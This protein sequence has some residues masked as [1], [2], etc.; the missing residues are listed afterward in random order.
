[1]SQAQIVREYD[2]LQP[3]RVKLA[4]VAGGFPVKP[5][6]DWFD[7]PHLETETPLTVTADGRVYGHIAPWSA[8][9]IGLPGNVPPPRS[10]SN[11]A[12]F[13]T[14]VVACA[15]GRDVPVGQL[16]MDGGHAPLALDASGAVAH[17]DNTTTAVADVH[18]GED[19]FGIWVA[20][21]LRPN[22]NDLQ[23][24]ALRASA[25]SGDWRPINGGLE[26]VACLQVNTPGFPTVRARVASGAVTAL[27][28]AG[29]QHMMRL[30]YRQAD[31]DYQDRLAG[32]ETVVASLVDE[33]KGD[34]RKRVG[35]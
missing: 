2:P 23:I 4:L 8:Q 13:H 29:A 15:D 20:G 28:A 7:D 32:L 17:Y 35:K 26:L 11:Y 31:A 25:P 30:R 24:R 33:R 18:A 12:Y 34:L 5:P 9:H 27:V 10:R 3:G 16:T 19:R 6:P 14:G 1:M 21:A 22:V